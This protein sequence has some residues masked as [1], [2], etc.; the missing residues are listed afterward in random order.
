MS[1]KERG[2]VV[3]KIGGETYTFRLS[4]NAM[5]DLEEVT[6]KPLPELLAQIVENP[7]VSVLRDVVWAALREHQPDADQRLAGSICGAI[8]GGLNDLIEAIM[9]AADF[10]SADGDQASGNVKAQ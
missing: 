5:C 8:G 2:D 9:T 7:S 1:S 3:R 6:G 4:F 10:A